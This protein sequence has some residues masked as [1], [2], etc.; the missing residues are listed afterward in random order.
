MGR[1]SQKFDRELFT[2]KL[3]EPARQMQIESLASNKAAGSAKS[4]GSVLVQIV[5]GQLAVLRKWLETVDRICREVWQTQ[6]ESI[7]PDF[8]REILV[9][10]AITAI[11]ARAGVTTSCV[12]RTAAQTHEDP[13]AARHHLAMEV[14]RLKAKVANR[15]ETEARE[16]EYQKAP[17]AQKSGQQSQLDEIGSIR[18]L[19]EDATKDTALWL[20][21]DPSAE[22]R[23]HVLAMQERLTDLDR[24]FARRVE[25]RSLPNDGRQWSETV[26]E[27]LSRLDKAREVRGNIVGKDLARL[28][29]RLPTELPCPFPAQVSQ[30][31]APGT[32]LRGTWTPIRTEPTQVPNLPPDYPNDLKPQ[33][34]LILAEAVRKFPEQTRTLELCKCVISELTP[35]FR[36]AV[37][38]KRLRADLVS[39]HIDELLHYLLV[40]N[41]DDD[42]KRFWFKQEVRKSDEW[43]RL[44]REIVEVSAEPSGSTVESKPMKVAP[45]STREA[46]IKP[47]LEKK[48][49]SVQEWARKAN[50]DFHTADN[51]LKGETKPYPDT[52]KKLADALARV[53]RARLI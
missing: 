12:D 34:H 9:P 36:E 46:F 24:I 21:A 30:A 7:T 38:G 4:A 42:N 22:E 49:F 35:H 13:Y 32:R 25:R 37:R 50:V 31:P 10:E 17:A 52:L 14:D 1:T 5:D 33:T 16:L 41:C 2:R 45:S 53:Y 40:S 23:A 3:S 51:Y 47:I 39:P 27:V 43:L 11:G 18:G 26:G 6:G 20:Q 29:E 48:G 44:A 19:I 15:Y 28:A 8:V